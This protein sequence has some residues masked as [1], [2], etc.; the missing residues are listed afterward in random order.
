[1][2]NVSRKQAADGQGNVLRVEFDPEDV[3]EAR[4]LA[5]YQHL[6][7]QGRGS[8]KRIVV[9][10]FAAMQSRFERTGE[11]VTPHQLDDLISTLEGKS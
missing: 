2:Q 5:M 6:A 9:T 8:R 7:K 11:I 1:M 4:A 10:L 3:H